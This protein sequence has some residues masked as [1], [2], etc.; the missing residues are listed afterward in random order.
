MKRV[1][2]LYK[3]LPQWRMA[4]FNKLKATLEEDDI[5]LELVYGKLKGTASNKKDEVVLNWGKYVENS[6]ISMGGKE[7]IW[8]PATK[9][10]KN[11]DLVI[12]EQANKLLINYYLIIRKIFLGKTFAFWGHGQNLQEN[13]K[14][15]ANRFKKIYSCKTDWW[16]AYTEN[17]RQKIVE[18]GFN[19]NKISVLN[20]TIETDFLISAYNLQTAEKIQRIKD[21][22]QIGEGPIGLYCGGMYKEKRI[23][24]LLEAC[25]RIKSQIDN[26]EMIFVGGGSEAEKIKAASSKF[27]WIHYIGPVF[28]KGKVPFFFMSDLFLMPGLVGLAIIDTFAMQ[29]PIITTNYEYHS[30]EIEYLENN[31]NGVM[32]QNN[33]KE[34]AEEVVCLL[35][36]KSRLEMLKEN[37]KTSAKKYPLEYMV[38]SF[39]TGILKCLKK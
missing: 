16:F 24:F 18:I 5:I 9:H 29:T 36:N 1:V 32:T 27:K 11:A 21:E 26:F 37:C 19:Q 33:I 4:F 10:I 6:F 2:I 39:K 34:Y 31:V 7:L 38:N 14:S 12:V 20:N 22:Y 3:F 30:P 35:K 17:V 13:P 8:Q 15:F 28:D 25:N 23:D